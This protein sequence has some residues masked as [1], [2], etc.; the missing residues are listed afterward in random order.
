ANELA[1]LRQKLDVPLEEGLREPDAA[2]VSVVEIERRFEELLRLAFAAF[3]DRAPQVAPVAHHLERGDGF[4]RVEKAE[5]AALAWG[6]REGQALDELPVERHPI[7][8]GVHLVFGQFQLARA[9][10][11]QSEELYLLEP[12]YLRADQDIAPCPPR[13]AA[14]ALFVFSLE[15][16]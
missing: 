12:D 8:R 16:L 7:G 1:S 4:E 11:L 15:R 5:Q 10:V 2:G 13:R 14:H 6:H 9:H 3:T